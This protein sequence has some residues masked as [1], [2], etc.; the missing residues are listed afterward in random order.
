M[1]MDVSSRKG[2]AAAQ[3][4]QVHTPCAR[5]TCI[6]ASVSEIREDR[7]AILRLEGQACGLE[8][9]KLP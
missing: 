1:Q 9:E 3:G 5:E 6:I 8:K 2:G 4:I 7:D